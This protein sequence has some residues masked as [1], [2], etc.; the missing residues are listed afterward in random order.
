MGG[1]RA[2]GAG[3]RGAGAATP[4]FGAGQYKDVP[5]N[6]GNVVAISAGAGHVLA[7]RSN[8]T[9]V[10]WGYNSAGQASP[11]ADLRHVTAI[12]AGDGY[13]LALLAGGTVRA[14]G[15]YAPRVPRHL[16]H[17]AAISAGDTHALALLTDGTV[18]E[19]GTPR[20]G[21]PQPPP[22]LRDVVAIAAGDCQSYALRSDGSVVAW[23]VSDQ[24]P[25]PWPREM[26]TDPQPSPPDEVLL[27]ARNGQSAASLQR[28]IAV[29]TRA[30]H[31]LE[32]HADGTLAASGSRESA[33]S[34][35]PDFV[36]ALHD[37]TA[38]GAGPTHDLALR[39]DG[40][41]VTWGRGNQ[42][43]L[44]VPPAV[45]DVLAVAAGQTFSVAL[46]RR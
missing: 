17:V 20:F 10:G 41:V 5:S 31:V 22:G 9:V 12:A 32:L 6:L 30:F 43:L 16:E 36:A 29:A 7:L 37:V 38:I 2:R 35:L 40:T 15:R 26:T 3:R 45:H 23:G 46:V 4:A 13:S 14:W 39:D 42:R 33:V 1:G 18:R 25:E 44:R 11:P 19:F 27:A 34:K 28:S 24:L 8:G 21:R